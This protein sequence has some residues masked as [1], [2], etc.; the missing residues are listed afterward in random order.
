MLRSRC[1]DNGVSVVDVELEKSANIQGRKSHRQTCGQGWRREDP[2][3]G[4]PKG[5]VSSLQA[6]IKLCGK[7][8]VCK[9]LKGKLSFFLWIPLPS[10]CPRAW[11]QVK[12]L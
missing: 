4:R 11:G 9:P 2:L 12:A 8:A 7:A 1:Q 6:V 5:E 10:N 3:E